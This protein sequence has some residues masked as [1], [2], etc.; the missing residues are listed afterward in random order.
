[1]IVLPAI[2]IRN[3]GLPGELLILQMTINGYELVLVDE[4]GSTHHMSDFSRILP[5]GCPWEL[6]CTLII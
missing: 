6:R 2:A 3:D 1:M 5:D 4:G